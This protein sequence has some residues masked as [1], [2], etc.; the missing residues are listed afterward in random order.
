MA[1]EEADDDTWGNTQPTNYTPNPPR[2]KTAGTVGTNLGGLILGAERLLTTGS[3][4]NPGTFNVDSS[5]AYRGQT[6]L[7]PPAPR[8]LTLDAQPG[9][10][11]VTGFSSG[12][13]YGRFIN[14]APG[15]FA[16][17]GFATGNLGYGRAL[18]AQPGTFIVTGSAAGTLADR[19]MNA[20][21]GTYAV[22]GFAAGVPHDYNLNAQPGAFAVTG[23]D[24]GA[25]VGRV[26]NAQ[27]GSFAVTGFDVSLIRDYNLNAQ[28]GSYLVT[29]ADA[30]L[31]YD[32]LTI[33]HYELDA[34]PGVFGIFGSAIGGGAAHV[35]NAEPGSFTITGSLVQ[36]I[37]PQRTKMLSSIVNP[38]SRRIEENKGDLM[39]VG[40]RK[41]ELVANASGS[42]S[43]RIRV[44]GSWLLGVKLNY[45][46]AGSGTDF[47]L[48]DATRTLLT[49]AN[50]NTDGFYP[51]RE[52]VMD[53]DANPLGLYEPIVIFDGE[54][55][56]DL[57]GAGSGGTVEVTVYY[58]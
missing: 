36:I 20:V 2:Q 48:R 43:K 9:S 40:A 17:T 42:D 29:G 27:P 13:G 56:L 18:N 30:D 31:V 6:I 25:L 12:G 14:A 37:A 47:V 38:M 23:A 7:I 53:K 5:A 1:G 45:G 11:A 54:L 32:A 8:A 22:T 55:F 44:E 4:E 41:K 33:N 50:N 49:V 46:T 24:V 57:A 26:L 3:A 51:V 39:A 16:V 10:F 58:Q 15:S 19:V 35:L 21:P 34:Q 52:E 28:P